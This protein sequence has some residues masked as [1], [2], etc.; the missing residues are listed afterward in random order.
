MI[1]KALIIRRDGVEI[2]KEYAQVTAES[3]EK[4][5]LEYE[6]LKAVEF[7]SSKDAIESVGMKYKY[8]AKHSSQACCTA[9]HIQAFRR[10]IEINEPCLILEHDALVLGNVK[11]VEIPDNAVVTFGFRVGKPNEYLPSEPATKVTKIENSTGTHAYAITPT[12]AKTLL[13]KMKIEGVTCDIDKFLMIGE[14]YRLN[15]KTPPLSGLPLYVCDPPQAVCWVRESTMTYKTNGQTKEGRVGIET[16]RN[17]SHNMELESWK[18]GL[19][20]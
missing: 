13:N 20:K 7:L 5:G 17:K 6:F 9:S 1:K 8:Q 16:V 18:R 12:T 15:A 4:H 11:D 10:V 19:Q 14:S 2:S 3:C